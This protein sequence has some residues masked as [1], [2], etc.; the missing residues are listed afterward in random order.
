MVV[1]TMACAALAVLSLAL[2]VDGAAAHMGRRHHAGRPHG[3]RLHVAWAHGHRRHGVHARVHEAHRHGVDAVRV[4]GGPPDSGVAPGGLTLPG[5]K[6]VG[7]GQADQVGMAS[8]YPGRAAGRHGSTLT[9]AHRSWPF[10]THVRVTNLVN[11]R[12][13][14]VSI[15][16]RGPFIRGRVIDV[17]LGAA[18][19]LGFVGQGVTK[20]RLD[21]LP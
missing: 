12:A 16:D 9:A 7:P 17:S 6:Q 13:V 14:V 20:V 11:G 8:F 1:R 5:L 4:A 10:G 19:S 18:R 15:N 21:K 3:H 2:P